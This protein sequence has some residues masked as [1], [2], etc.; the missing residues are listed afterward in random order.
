[1]AGLPG[2]LTCC[3]LMPLMLYSC[4]SVS[5]RYLV[6]ETYSADR[7]SGKGIGSGTIAVFP[8]LDRGGALN[9]KHFTFAHISDTLEER[10]KDLKFKGICWNAKEC[11]SQVASEDLDSLFQ[12]LY[13][14]K[15]LKVNQFDT[16]WQTFEG[17][18]LLVFYLR[19]AMSIYTFN[20]IVRKRVL[21]EAELWDC[22]EVE[23]VWRASVDGT[24]TKK[25]VTDA[26]FLASG[27]GTIIGL[28]PKVLPEYEEGRW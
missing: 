8:F 5:T 15:L 21:V 9:G 24:C 3:L 11:L 17:R 23:V 4:A 26:E 6:K 2:L 7:F 22:R 19:K 25:Q 10:R 14:S 27:A 16:I 12:I 13:E 20:K 1:M 18:Y 28:L